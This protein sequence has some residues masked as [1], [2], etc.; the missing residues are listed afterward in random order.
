MAKNKTNFTDESVLDFLDKVEN[1][2]KRR[3]SLLLVKWMEEV[4]GEQAR[5][6]ESSII[7]F[8]AYS[9]KYESGHEGTAP[10]LG[11]SPRK[12]AISLYIFTG[13]DEHKQ[14][15]EN[16]GKF[17]TGKACI[18]VKKLSDLNEKNLKELMQ[19]TINYISNKFV[20]LS[21]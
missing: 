20:R 10:L 4:S 6:W 5:M 2:Q 14:L 7:G 11:F 9:Y 3:D 8:G 1:E 21:T 13:L 18:Y 15:L 17:T 12:S 16:L 19:F